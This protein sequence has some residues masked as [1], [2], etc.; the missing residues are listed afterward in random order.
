M[1][2]WMFYALLST[3]FAGTTAVL[4]KYG[5]QHVNPD[6]GLMI[7]TSVI[8]ILVIAAALLGH[9]FADASHLTGREVWLLVASGA[10]A[11]LSWIFYFRALK[12][13]PLTY[14]ASIDKA[15][16]VVTLALSFIL[17]REPLKPQVL[18]GGGL[19][20]AGMLVLVWK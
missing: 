10:T 5:L 17:L 14:V 20:L 3:L 7:R 19:I 15:S 16:I 9:A 6:L 11:F 1:E 4:A 18:L 12:E 2:K 13:G 8:F